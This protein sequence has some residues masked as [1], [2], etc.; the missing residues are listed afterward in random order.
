MKDRYARAHMRAALEYSQL[1]YCKDNQVGCVIVKDDCP[2]AIGFNGMPPGW[3]NCCEDVNGKT[4]AEV[5]HA[6][7]NAI[8]RL[9]RKDSSGKGASLFCTLA[10]CL[11]CAKLIVQ[12]GIKEVYYIE[13][14]PKSYVGLEF[15]ARC[16][17]PVIQMTR[18]DTIAIPHNN[19]NKEQHTW[20]QQ[21]KREIKRLLSRLSN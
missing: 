9:A 17:M 15:L 6:E 13:D 11:P 21:F 19:N 2:I 16:Q 5:Y 3:E 7:A 8:A 10:P 12:T 18:E 4:H 1:S 14:H 20:Q